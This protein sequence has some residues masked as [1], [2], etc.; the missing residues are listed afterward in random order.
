MLRP[1]PKAERAEFLRMLGVLVTANNEVS[2]AP[3]EAA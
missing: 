2:R 1:L 3:N